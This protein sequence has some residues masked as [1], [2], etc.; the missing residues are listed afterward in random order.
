[1]VLVVRPSAEENPYNAWYWKTDITGAAEGVKIAIVREGFGQLRRENLGYPPVLGATPIEN[2][3]RNT[4][5]GHLGWTFSCGDDRRRYPH[6][7]AARNRPRRHDPRALSH[8][9]RHSTSL[10]P[11][12]VTQIRFRRESANTRQ[13]AARRQQGLQGDAEMAR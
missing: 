12:I 2:L 1:M 5:S 3:F 8:S 6:L 10:P 9:P 11:R 4:G 13:P 7:P